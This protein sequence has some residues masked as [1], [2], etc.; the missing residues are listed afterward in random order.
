MT[1]I[2]KLWFTTYEMDKISC[3]LADWNFEPLDARNMI[4]L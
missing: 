1:T 2:S 4:K 3:K